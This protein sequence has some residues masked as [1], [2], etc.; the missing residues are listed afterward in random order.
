MAPTDVSEMTEQGDSRHQ[1]LPGRFSRRTGAKA[2]L[3]S[4]R[5]VLLVRERHDD[6]TPFWT[7][8]GGGVD[9]GETP[10]E[11]LRRELHEELCCRSRIGPPVSAFW[12]AHESLAGTVSRYTVFECSL[13]TAPEP[14]RSEGVYETR[15]VDPQAPPTGTLPQVRLVCRAA[16]CEPLPASD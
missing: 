11:G 5:R 9:A 12:Y 14:N 6:G 13:L 4:D 7:L 8:P 1:P 10:R 3:T 2:L 15:W 16:L